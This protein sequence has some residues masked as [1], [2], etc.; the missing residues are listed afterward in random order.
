MRALTRFAQVAAVTAIGMA[1]AG[2][3]G[4]AGQARSAVPQKPDDRAIVHVLNRIGFGPA[5]G[6]LE[7]V[8]TIGLAAYID[9]QL[10]P[11]RLDDSRMA[12]RLAAFDTLSKSTQEMAQQYYLP[13]QMARREA[14]RQQAAQ[15]PAG[16]DPSIRRQRRRRTTPRAER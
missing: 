7:R 11:E 9:Q 12:A 5:P 13:A 15:T 8:R 14:Q 1:V 6:D 10:Q 3:A 4:Q 16:S 2:V